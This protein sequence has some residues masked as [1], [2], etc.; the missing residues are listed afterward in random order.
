LAFAEAELGAQ[1]VVVVLELL[2]AGQGALMHAFPVADL[3]SQGQ[4][5]GAKGTVVTGQLGRVLRGEYG[6]RKEN[7]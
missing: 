3:L 6:G 1:L 2:Q 5:L 4:N 7:R